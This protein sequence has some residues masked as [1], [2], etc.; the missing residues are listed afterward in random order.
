MKNIILQNCYKMTRAAKSIRLLQPNAQASTVT[1]KDGQD[2]AG[3]SMR[4]TGL[5]LSGQS[6]L[7]QLLPFHHF[8]RPENDN[9]HDG[10]GF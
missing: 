6:D 10:N 8:S 4:G 3:A 2:R 5:C 1:Q 7:A 9:V